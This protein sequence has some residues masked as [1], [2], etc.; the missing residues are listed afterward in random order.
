MS[1]AEQG[2]WRENAFKQHFIDDPFLGENYLERKDVRIA[3]KKTTV[4]NI[5]VGYTKKREPLRY[6]I[7]PEML[8]DAI[9]HLRHVPQNQRPSLL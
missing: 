5:L 8:V 4:R 1:R 9:C 7:E 2:K 6:V 3:G